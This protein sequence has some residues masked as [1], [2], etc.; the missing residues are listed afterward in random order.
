MYPDDWGKCASCEIVSH[1]AYA[2]EHLKSMKPNG[3]KKGCFF[4]QQLT[5]DETLYHTLN[6]VDGQQNLA[7]T[8]G[9]RAYLENL[10][11]TNAK[12]TCLRK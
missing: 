3:L 5:G 1:C 12:S 6:F 2:L 10:R 11:K 7:H 8:V 9:E 4:E